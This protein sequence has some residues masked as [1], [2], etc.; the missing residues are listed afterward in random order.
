VTNQTQVREEEAPSLPRVLSLAAHELSTPM[1]VLL[2]Y[3]RMLLREQAGPLNDKQRKMLEEADRSGARIGALVKELSE[4]GKLESRELPLPRMPFDLAALATETALGMG[5]D[6]RGV[7]V[8]A[9][10]A[11]RPVRVTGDRV[12]LSTAIRALIHAAVRE[13][14]ESGVVVVECSVVDTWGVVVV[15]DDALL[16]LLVRSAGVA[17]PGLDEYRG[18]MGLYLPL[19]K[20]VGEYHGGAIW[21]IGG[22]QRAFGLRLPLVP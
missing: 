2:G 13:H 7:E 19:G 3:I 22:Q 12:R 16:P 6:S 4:F 10:A 8:E 9:R 14:L 5:D 17:P 20:R 11:G 18:G 15:G 21:S 1:T